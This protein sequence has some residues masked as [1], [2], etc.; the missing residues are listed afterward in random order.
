MADYNAMVKGVVAEF[1]AIENPSALTYQ[2]IVQSRNLSKQQKALL[3]E[4]AVDYWAIQTYGKRQSKKTSSSSEEGF[5]IVGEGLGLVGEVLGIAKAIVIDMP[6]GVL[7]NHTSDEL[8]A[9]AKDYLT[10]SG[11]QPE[12]ALAKREAEVIKELKGT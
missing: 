12:E 4:F 2:E 8:Y 11:N 10:G 7:T 5:G 6:L 3:L 1:Q 9:K